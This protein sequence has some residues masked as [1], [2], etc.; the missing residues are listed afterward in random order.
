MKSHWLYFKRKVDP[1][2]IKRVKDKFAKKTHKRK[3]DL[4]IKRKYKEYHYQESKRVDSFIVHM[5]IVEIA[6]NC[7]RAVVHQFKDLGEESQFEVLSSLSI[8]MKS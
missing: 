6:L 3:S 7:A 8:K 5:R 2:V 4:P 1:K